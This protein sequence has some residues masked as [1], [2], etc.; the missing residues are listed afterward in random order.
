ML[1]PTPPMGWN[2]WNTFGEHISEEL[3]RQT[4]DAFVSHGLKD[5]G[6]TYVVIDDHWELRE[7]DA[8]GRLIPDPKKFPNGIKP[9]AD[10][11]HSKDL[12]FGIYSCAGTL[13]CGTKAGSFGYDHYDVSMQMAEL[14]LLP[15]I[16]RRPDAIIVAAGTSC[17]HQITDGAG[18]GAVHLALLLDSLTA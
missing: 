17:R 15:A 11:V 2:S 18:R 16:R 1:A 7:R 4:A 14:N 5:A 6:Y 8:Q 10:Y 3:V 9:V 12:K 13:T